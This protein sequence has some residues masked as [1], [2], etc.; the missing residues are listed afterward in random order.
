M[1]VLMAIAILCV[2]V[3]MIHQD[4]K[5]NENDTEPNK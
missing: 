5:N 2:A 4:M 3:A 1:I